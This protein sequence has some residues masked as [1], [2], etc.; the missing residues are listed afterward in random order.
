MNGVT[1]YRDRSTETF[2]KRTSGE[3]GVHPPGTLPLGGSDGL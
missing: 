3:R 2:S 1:D